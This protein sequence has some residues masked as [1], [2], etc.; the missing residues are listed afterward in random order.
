MYIYSL[1]NKY[2]GESSLFFSMSLSLLT[3][4]KRRNASPTLNKVAKQWPTSW[5][6]GGP[7]LVLIWAISCS[8]SFFWHSLTS[9]YKCNKNQRKKIIIKW[10][11]IRFN[12][13][14]FNFHDTEVLL[15]EQ[16]PTLSQETGA[17][18]RQKGV[19]WVQVSAGEPLHWASN[20]DWVPSLC[21]MTKIKRGILSMQS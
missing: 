10:I 14:I 17:I 15:F 9:A 12:Q 11:N 7:G 13:I 6:I 5:R 1:V 20:C 8:T 3:V 16:L 21:L 19:V 2:V 4:S 18:H